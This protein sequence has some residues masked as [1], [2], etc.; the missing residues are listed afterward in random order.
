VHKN[1]GV[2]G[3]HFDTRFTEGSELVHW[4]FWSNVSG[5]EKAAFYFGTGEYIDT[6]NG[7]IR[8]L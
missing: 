4:R 7:I 8:K 6:R 1:R 3:W 2:A 5:G